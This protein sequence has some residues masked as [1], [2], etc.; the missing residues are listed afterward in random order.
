MSTFIFQLGGRGNGGTIRAR[1]L[2]FGLLRSLFGPDVSCNFFWVQIDK[3]L[4]LLGLRAEI[5]LADVQNLEAKWVMGKILRNK[6]L[7]AIL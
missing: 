2:E 7:E 6:D 4:T 3:I 1:S 5:Y